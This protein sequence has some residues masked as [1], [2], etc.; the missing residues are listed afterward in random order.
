MRDFELATVTAGFDRSQ[1]AFNI[2]VGVSLGVT[3]AALAELPGALL[4]R[5]RTM[6]HYKD[7]KT[8]V[9]AFSIAGGVVL[10]G[11]TEACRVTGAEH[12]NK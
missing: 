12:T 5:V 10:P 2:G 6:P 1:C 11:N 7:V 4:R 9:Q 3:G 8:P